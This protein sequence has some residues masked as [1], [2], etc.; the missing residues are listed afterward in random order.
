[1]FR[2]AAM[3]YRA[4]GADGLYLAD[5]PWPYT[6]REYRILREMGDP[7]IFARKS[8]HYFVAREES[9][10]DVFA[11]ERYLPQELKEGVP[12]KVRFM[13]G[14]R[15][16]EARLEDE[17]DRVILGVRV[18]QYCPEDQLRFRFNGEVVS[19]SRVSHFY[20]GLVAYSAA[21]GGLPER[22][23]THYW[24]T[25][26]LPIDLVREGDNE[27]EVTL[28]RHFSALIAER[29]LHQVELRVEYKEP[30]RPVGGQM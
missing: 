5:L 6:E 14:D 13:V 30:F 7:D 12:A 4:M 16:E 18:V 3:N 9:R 23:D 25:F 11:P 24:F 28:E 19:P 17:L 22:I 20:G 21:R 26:D 8:K 15:L 29:V 27:V 10:A 2:A 1:M